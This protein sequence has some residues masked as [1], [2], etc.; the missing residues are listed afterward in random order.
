VQLQTATQITS[1][2]INFCPDIL[3]QIGDSKGSIKNKSEELI[4]KP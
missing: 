4:F 1:R 2:I 3:N